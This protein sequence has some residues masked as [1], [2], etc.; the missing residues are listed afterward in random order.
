MQNPGRLNHHRRSGIALLSGALA[1]VLLWPGRAAVSAVPP[2]NDGVKAVAHPTAPARGDTTAGGRQVVLAQETARTLRTDGEEVAGCRRLPGK[3]AIVKLNLKP[4][5][6]IPDLIAW[7]ASIT[8]RQFLVPG[9]VLASTKKV[10]IYS[11]LPIT[12]DGAYQLFLT[13]LDSVGLTVQESGKFFRIIE[14]SKAKSTA[15]PLFGFNGERLPMQ[16]HGQD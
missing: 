7:I 13:G 9:T 11:P 3:K 16:R 8:C 5:T 15:V 12:A 2:D 6:E 10:T 4:E 1:I 14:T